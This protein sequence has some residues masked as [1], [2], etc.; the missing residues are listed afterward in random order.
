MIFRLFEQ[1]NKIGKGKASKKNIQIYK[2]RSDQMNDDNITEVDRSNVGRKP[3]FEK[4]ADKLDDLTEYAA[5]DIS[6]KDIA[7]MLGIGE[8]TFYRLLSENQQFREAYQKGLDDRKYTLE[9]ALFK[10]AEGFVAEEKQVVRDAE[11]NVIKEV[12]NEKHYVP[13][14]TALIFSLKNI[15]GEKY[16]DRVETVTDFNINIS[17]INQLSDKEL[18]RMSGIDISGIDYEIE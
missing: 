18:Q 2:R 16:K 4:V 14:T 13:D 1:V 3:A 6:N 15:Y 10:R 17:Q 9:K 5:Q 8:S 7:E 11:G 12:V